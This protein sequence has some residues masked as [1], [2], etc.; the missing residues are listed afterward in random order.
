MADTV[1]LAVWAGSLVVSLWLLH[2]AGGPLGQPGSWDELRWAT[3]FDLAGRLLHVVASAVAWYL[4][5]ATVLS[6]VAD[7]TGWQGLARATRRITPR[8]VHTIAVRGSSVGLLLGSL[9]GGVVSTGAAGA[10]PAG[11]TLPPPAASTAAAPAP[12]GAAAPTDAAGSG[13]GTAT[14]H[15]LPADPGA[16]D[17][18]ADPFPAGAPTPEV[19][20]ATM[21]RIPPDPSPAAAPAPDAGAADAAT[22][23]PRQP[24]PPPTGRH[25]E[26]WRVEVGDSL[27]SIA[28]AVLRDTHPGRAPSEQDVARYWRTVVDANRERLAVPDDPDLL[29]PGQEILLPRPEA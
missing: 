22:A 29:L 21:A 5:V 27:W 2:G 1:R 24:A 28:E 26:T 4:L 9:T 14:M 8:V 6:V 18:R 19:G 16:P 25:D 11:A 23:E 7:R 17:G 3:P 15:R 20:T 10:S 13:S 12:D